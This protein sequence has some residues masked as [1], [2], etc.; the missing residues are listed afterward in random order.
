MTGFEIVPE[1]TAPIAGEVT[2]LRRHLL[3]P[4]RDAVV[5]FSIFAIASMTLG[6]ASSSA[7][8]N[9][10]AQMSGVAQPAAVQVVTSADDSK[11]LT[12]VAATSGANA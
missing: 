9:G 5:A 10:Y 2:R 12:F 1:A 7:S 4:A 3:R 11:T 6:S 8:P